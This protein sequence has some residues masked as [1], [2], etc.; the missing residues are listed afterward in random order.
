[1]DVS[2]WL[3]L[4]VYEDSKGAESALRTLTNTELD[5]RKIYLRKVGCW[6]GEW[7]GCTVNYGYE[8]WLHW[9]A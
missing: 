8:E 2:V 1:M 3:R 5:G 7:Y 6:C 9:R 4:A